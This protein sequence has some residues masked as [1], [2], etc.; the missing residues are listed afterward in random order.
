MNPPWRGFYDA[1]NTMPD[2]T[3]YWRWADIP[4]ELI[5][6]WHAERVRNTGGLFD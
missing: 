5:K 4:P 3:K 2:R 6:K 1:A